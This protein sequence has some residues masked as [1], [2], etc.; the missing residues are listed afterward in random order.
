V[1]K[2]KIL[3]VDDEVG[4][5][6]ALQRALVARGYEVETAADGPEA[7]SEAEVFAPDLIV[8]DLNLPEFDG[9]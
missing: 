8:L 5:R 9:M 1:K 4:I 6:R 7:V 2:E 3:V